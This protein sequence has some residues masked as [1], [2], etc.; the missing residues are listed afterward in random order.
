MNSQ[1]GELPNSSSFIKECPEIEVLMTMGSL[2]I[3]TATQRPRR[4]EQTS[5]STNEVQVN[6]QEVKGTTPKDLLG[7]NINA[8]ENTA[9][10]KR[11]VLEESNSY[12][13]PSK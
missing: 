3:D 13:N 5:L 10:G 6:A 12:L 1:E 4:H 8:V 11:S 7:T 9:N 2:H